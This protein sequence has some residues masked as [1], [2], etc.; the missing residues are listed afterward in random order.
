MKYTTNKNI[1][2]LFTKNIRQQKS[3]ANYVI[4]F[5]LT[6][7]ELIKINY[8]E[9]RGYLR[10]RRTIYRGRVVRINYTSMQFFS[11]PWIQIGIELEGSSLV[12]MALGFSLYR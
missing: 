5:A 3:I 1:R 6:E 10:R 7:M 2:I 8:Q 12:S 9:T 4:I 11:V